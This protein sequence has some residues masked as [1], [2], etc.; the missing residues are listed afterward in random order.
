MRVLTRAMAKLGRPRRFG[1]TKRFEFA[2][3]L[4]SNESA[5]REFGFKNGV[6]D[7][8]LVSLRLYY[9]PELEL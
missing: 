8:L 1:I 5:D 7:L 4:G 6:G 3:F 9:L 2:R